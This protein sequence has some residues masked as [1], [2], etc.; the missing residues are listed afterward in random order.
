MPVHEI[1]RDFS[2]AAAQ[3]LLRVVESNDSGEI[4][5]CLKS[6]LGS[7][8]FEW[9]CLDV[10]RGRV[11]RE[12]L[13]SNL[14]PRRFREFV[15]RSGFLDSP[16]SSARRVWSDH[17]ILLVK[18]RTG[19][20]TPSYLVAA[21]G[22]SKGR[23]KDPDSAEEDLDLHLLSRILKLA[24]SRLVVVEEERL[25]AGILD[26]FLD[27]H[28]CILFIFDD[29]CNLVEKHPAGYLERVPDEIYGIA[30][31]NCRRREK[32]D[33]VQDVYLADLG[34]NY[35]V[36]SF[37]IGDHSLMGY[38][39]LVLVVRPVEANQ[40]LIRRKLSR[41]QLT[42]RELEIA[43][44]ILQGKTNRSIADQLYISSDT[45]KTHCK[46]IFEKLKIT[47]RTELFRKVNL[48]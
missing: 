12:E 21:A 13:A 11:S 18:A 33:R 30:R 34:R 39:Y 38:L 44:L 45:V 37:W 42:G 25:R 5:E 7:P 43:E 10:V 14:G 26:H 20:V 29:A 47:R 28:R 41:Y 32:W 4:L 15:R 3:F 46:H 19:E 2:N 22:L 23:E 1:S 31:A 40:S 24:L 48:G 17:E 35:E 27:S 36:R 6:L 9:Y 16:E 8:L